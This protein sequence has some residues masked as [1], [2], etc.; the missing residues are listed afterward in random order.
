MVTRMLSTENLSFAAPRQELAL[1]YVNVDYWLER[2]KPFDS[3]LFDV[4]QCNL[5]SS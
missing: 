5:A 3:I 4:T 2:L 1:T